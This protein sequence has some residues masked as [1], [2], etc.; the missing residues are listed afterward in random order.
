MDPK[1][2]EIE[3]KMSFSTL[4]MDIISEEE[5]ERSSLTIKLALEDVK[6]FVQELNLQIE[7][8]HSRHVKMPTF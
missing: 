1:T 3:V 2:T 6:E 5:T 7:M 4:N 8:S